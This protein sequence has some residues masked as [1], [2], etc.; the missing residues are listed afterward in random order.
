MRRAWLLLL[1][2]P[3]GCFQ[4]DLSAG[5]FACDRDGDCPPGL[6]CRA[7]PQGQ[8]CVADGD[9]AADLAGDPSAQ[10]GAADGAM[11]PPAGPCLGRGL[12][13][14]DW[15]WACTG[16]FAAGGAAALCRDPGFHI[17]NAGDA[18][19]LAAW[20]ACNQRIGFY[21]SEVQ[22]ERVED[23][24]GA[25][26]SIDCDPGMNIDL[27]LGLL[28]CGREP[29]NNVTRSVSV[30]AGSCPPLP[31]ALRCDRTQAWECGL[32]PGTLSRTSHSRAETQGGG[33]LCC[34]NR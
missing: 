10:D 2:A 5:R 9:G 17:C 11:P 18:P 21:A 22:I 13:L 16:N 3:V 34:R 7:T 1:V 30:R 26:F 24:D 27:P 25:T 8:R 32:G 6:V 33:V 28:G 19:V 23:G 14:S 31:T 15:V 4:V 12:Q 20:P 29:G